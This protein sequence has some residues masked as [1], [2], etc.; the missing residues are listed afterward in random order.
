[1]QR[2]G[3]EV[4]DLDERFSPKLGKR[5]ASRPFNGNVH[6]QTRLYGIVSEGSE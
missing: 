3:V 4:V 2:Q 1:M 6:K 5:R